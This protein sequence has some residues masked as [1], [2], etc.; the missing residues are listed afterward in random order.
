MLR[1]KAPREVAAQVFVPYGRVS[2]GTEDPYYPYGQCATYEPSQTPYTV[3]K[4]AMQ[5]IVV[6][7]EDVERVDIATHSLDTGEELDPLSFKLSRP[8]DIRI[9]NADPAAI[10]AVLSGKVFTETN[11]RSADIDFENHFNILRGTNSL[12]LPVPHHIP[13]DRF[14]L[15][16][17]YTTLVED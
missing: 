16:P 15:R 11:R 12:H 13:S 4:C 5:Q 2:A 3:R 1:K 9:I 14:M 6:T 17:C 7:V 8:A 10:R